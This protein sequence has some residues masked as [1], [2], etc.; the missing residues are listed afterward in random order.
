MTSR[1]LGILFKMMETW[2]PANLIRDVPEEECRSLTAYDGSRSLTDSERW[3]LIR[4]LCQKH[5]GEVRE[6]HGSWRYR[7]TPFPKEEKF[8]HPQYCLT[9]KEA[10]QRTTWKGKPA[11]GGKGK[12]AS[13]GGKGPGSSSDGMPA[14]GGKGQDSE[15]DN[16]FFSH[17]D[18]GAGHW[19]REATVTGLPELFSTFGDLATA[20]E[21]YEWW[22]QA[23]VFVH[24][25]L[26]GASNPA[27]QE[28]ARR[29][30]QATGY[31][32]HGR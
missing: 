12:P 5:R 11:S 30:F 23:R 21:L 14:S 18:S 29:R 4:D 16:T 8:L 2:Q 22:G 31:Y 20:R 3:S 28:A 24:K 15:T 25:R 1:Q 10:K 6:I 32:G 19:Q 26:H 7:S 9:A 27:R 17:D 13:S